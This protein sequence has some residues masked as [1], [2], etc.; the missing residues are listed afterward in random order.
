MKSLLR[1]YVRFLIKENPASLGRPGKE[2]MSAD[3][4]GYEK[5]HLNRK[6]VTHGDES[7]EDE[8]T[9]HLRDA[10]LDETEDTYGPVP[11]TGRD[12]HAVADQNDAY[13]NVTWQR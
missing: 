7:R 13:H 6:P 2:T 5:S 11:P 1:E 8:L 12:P 10:D 3:S 4:T 9:T